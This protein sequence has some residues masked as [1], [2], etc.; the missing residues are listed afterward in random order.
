MIIFSRNKDCYLFELTDIDR[1]DVSNE[2]QIHLNSLTMI[3]DWA[4]EYLCHPHP[5]LGRTGPVCPFVP[6]S[7]KKV[8]FF[9]TVYPEDDLE[10]NKAYDFIIKYRDFF[11]RG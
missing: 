9:L 3:V 10:E 8:L 2:F 4:K 7:M 5:Q 1:G 11:F 6:T